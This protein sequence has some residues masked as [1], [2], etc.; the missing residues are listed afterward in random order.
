MKRFFMMMLMAMVAVTCVMTFAACEKNNPKPD[1]IPKP[2]PNPTPNPGGT[3]I[4][5]I[6]LN[7]TSIEL[8]VNGRE[9]LTATV[10]P[11]NTSMRLLTWSSSN[12]KVAKVSSTGEVHGVAAG[13]AIIMVRGGN[14]SAS[15]SVTITGQEAPIGDIEVSMSGSI[16]HTTYTDGESATVTFSRIPRSIEEFKKVREQIGTEPHGAVALQLMACEMFHRDHKI[17]KQAF[18]LNNVLSNALQV[19]DRMKDL[20]DGD[21]KS[22]RPYLVAAFLKGATPENGYNP[23]KPYTVEIVVDKGRKYGY[24]RDYQAPVLH[25]MVL[26]RG[27]SGGKRHISVVRTL[28][29]HEPAAEGGKYFIVNQ[30]DGFHL[31]VKE[32]SLAAPY[33]GLD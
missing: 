32:K 24:I 31:R 17:G 29:P 1:P 15:C 21:P 6:K 33:K 20:F 23:D 28:S 8:S 11:A 9:T 27:D 4:K 12:E 16:N 19:A 2:G 30:S 13:K 5:A 3:T 14:A 22:N 26:T 25:L 18:D 7:K 10:E